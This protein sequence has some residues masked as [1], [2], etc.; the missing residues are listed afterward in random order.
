MRNHL[1]WPRIPRLITFLSTQQLVPC[2]MC[3]IVVKEFLV[4]LME[5]NYKRE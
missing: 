5:M 4:H 2:S 1:I 3:W